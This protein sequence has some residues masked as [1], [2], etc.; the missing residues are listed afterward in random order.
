MSKSNFVRIQIQKESQ[1]AKVFG[2]SAKRLEKIE[3]PFPS[4]KAEQQKIAD[5]LTS[6]D[7]LIVTQSQKLDALKAHKKGLMQQLF[8]RKGET[9]PRLRFPEFQNELE[10][11]AGSTSEIAFVLQGY[12]FPERYQGLQQGDYPFYKVSDI[13]RTLDSGNHYIDKATNYID[14]YSLKKL[15]AKLI[16]KGTTV[17]AKI[18]E[19]IRLNKRVVTTKPCVID[20]NMAGVKAIDGKATDLFVYYM[21]STVS[22]GD[23]AG[24]VVPAVS[25]SAI[26]NIPVSYPSSAEQQKIADC[27]SSIDDVITAQSKKLDALKAH[28]KGLMQQLFPSSKEVK[29]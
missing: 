20:N 27:L 9:L 6:L 28:K 25:K 4:D 2:I 21:W 5:C 26:E 22:L 12:G 14:H 17:F 16:P 23:H 19:A 15:K 11:V 1:G 24:G 13:S 10:W 8:P 18:G 3:I 7:E 29:A